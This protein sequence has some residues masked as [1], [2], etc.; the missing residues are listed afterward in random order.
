MNLHFIMDD[1]DL[2]SG[3]EIFAE[4]FHFSVSEDGIPVQVLQNND[5]KIVVSKSGNTACI[6]YTYKHQFFRA[7]GLLLENMRYEQ[8]FH[9]TETPQFQTN[10]PMIDVSQGNAVLRVETLQRLI[11]QMAAMG[12]NMLMLYTEDSYTIKEQPY[13]GYMRGKYSQDEIRQCDDYAHQFGIELIPCIQTLS[14]LRDVLKWNSFS[15]IKEDG[16]TLLVGEEKTYEFIEQM[17]IA[18]TSPVRSKR[19]HI[20]MDEAMRLG[21]GNYLTHNGLRS[22]S[23]IM[24]EHLARVLQITE[25]IGLKPMIWSD[26][27]FRSSGDQ[28]D[29]YEANNS[30][31]D[32]VIEAMPKNIQYVFWD[33]YHYDEQFYLDFIRKHKQFG[34]TPIFAGGIWNWKGFCLNYGATFAST[35]AAMAACKKEGVKEV[36]ATL[37]GDDGTEC[38]IYSSLLGLQLF[39]EHGY[40]DDFD[41]EKLKR[42]FQFCTGGNYEDFMDIRLVD[43]IP[44]TSEGNHEVVNP[45]R[46]LLW[47]QVLMGLFDRNIERLPIADHY[48]KMAIQYD[49]AMQR[50]GEWTP[51]FEILQKLCHVLAVKSEIGLRIT[52]AYKGGDI[53]LL[54]HFAKVE[55][56]DLIGRVEDLRECHLSQWLQLYKPFGWEVIDFRYGGLLASIRTAIRRLSDYA[57]GTIERLEELDEDRLLY[58]GQEGLVDC[59]WYKGMPSASRVIQSID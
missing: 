53:A 8:E 50:N 3:I 49:Q 32:A 43:E 45:S 17:I 25:K 11:T 40:A 38:H 7:L 47:Q 15:G 37:W 14:H 30:P 1:A 34:S 9:I 51:V 24:N 52:R 29:N 2:K 12:L 10:G 36:I 58:Q 35:N 20:G 22:K 27:Y 39:A 23:E 13:F 56:T 21:L 4:Q 5:N 57:G 41:E 6:Q 59:Y 42:R 33:Y 19:I 48:A 18:A 44:G 26:M 31:S 16:E 28:L 55:L 46:Y 54:N